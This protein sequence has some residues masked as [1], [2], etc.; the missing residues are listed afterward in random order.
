MGR[1]LLG[2]SRFARSIQR[3]LASLAHPINYIFRLDG[4]ITSA[5]SPRNCRR[6]TSA[7]RVGPTLR[8]QSFFPLQRAHYVEPRI[9]IRP[10]ASRICYLSKRSREGTRKNV[11][12]GRMQSRKFPFRTPLRPFVQ[13]DGSRMGMTSVTARPAPSISN[14]YRYR[15]L[16]F[17]FPLLSLHSGYHFNDALLFRLVISTG[18]HSTAER[19][20]MPR[21]DRRSP[22]SR[23]FLDPFSISFQSVRVITPP[24]IRENVCTSYKS[25]PAQ[26]KLFC[27][28]VEHGSTCASV[29]YF[30]DRERCPFREDVSERNII[31]ASISN[32]C[33]AMLQR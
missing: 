18:K 20:A 27:L 19:D 10:L 22:F 24:K 15:R 14:G 29:R 12:P 5:C 32:D 17:F 6:R 30:R 7:D 16:S 1:I 25:R 13:L 23:S 31:G 4:N 26:G 8:Q 21:V 9:C 3:E 2:K 33:R 11:H 28:Q